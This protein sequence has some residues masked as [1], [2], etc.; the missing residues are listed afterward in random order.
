MKNI[1]II[2]AG[3]VGSLAA[4]Y[5]AQHGHTVQIIERRPDMRK[6]RIS[7][8]RSI[9]LALSDRGWRGLAGAGIV[10]DIANV[11]IP[12]R[13]RMMHSPEGRQ[14]Y[15]QYGTDEQAIY[16]VSRGGIN[17]ELMDCAERHESIS[18][19]FNLRCVHVDLDNATAIF[20]DNDTH[21]RVTISSDCI[22]GADGAYS[23]VRG[24]MQFTD[25]FNY[26]QHYI[27]HGYKE[28]TIPALPDGSFALDK[29]SLHIWP[30]SSYMLIAL[31]NMDG[32]FTCTLFFP[33]EGDPSFAS[34]QTDDDIMAFFRDQ[35]A[36]AVPLMPTLLDDYRNNPTSSLMTVRCYP[37]SHKNKV[38]LIG[39][40]AHAIVPFFGQGM[41]CGFEDCYVLNSLLSE[42][43]EDNWGEM[44]AEFGKIRKPNGDAILQLALENFI[45][46]RDKVADTEFLLRKKIEGIAQEMQPKRFRSRYSMVS[47]SH[48]PYAETIT[49][50]KEQ[51]VLVDK[52]MAL[53]TIHDM[54][55]TEELR[56]VIYTTMAALPERFGDYSSPL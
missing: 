13:G 16:S 15:Q 17:M 27:E 50:A 38:L 51:D 32:S 40:A 36:D 30:R 20:E 54:L 5:F 55:G 35:F 31:P 23:A 41:N 47:F 43:H 6:T 44:F 19:R 26:E 42:Y 28:L 11:A 3:P 8:G 14:T 22:I 39:D 4:I 21:E 1:T 7:A 52:I 53:P 18:I 9:N 46:M 37:W 12:M 24:A 49:I 45:E 48:I 33:F 2:G 34:L 25:R 29:H 10:N 56:T